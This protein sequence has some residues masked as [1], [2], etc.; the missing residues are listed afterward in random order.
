M[1]LRLKPDGT[2][3]ADTPEEL[4]AYQFASRN[5]APNPNKKA[6]RVRRIVGDEEP[7]PESAQKLIALLFPEPKGLITSDVAK[8][9]GLSEPKAIGGSVTSL[10]AWGRRHNFTKKQLLTK[11]RRSNGSGHNVR[12]MALTENFRK[13]IKEGKVPGM[14]LEHSPLRA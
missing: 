6:P 2:V 8:A 11:T 10:T 9:L 14:K 12:V 4:V 5:G 13:M 1:S 7:I 3:E